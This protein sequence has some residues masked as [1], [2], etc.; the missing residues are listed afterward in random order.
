[1]P[2]RVSRRNFRAHFGGEGGPYSNLNEGKCYSNPEVIKHLMN[3]SI[4]SGSFGGVKPKDTSAL[5]R[6]CSAS[7]D[8][9]MCNSGD[10]SR[11]SAYPVNCTP[12][13]PG[14][15][16]GTYPEGSSERTCVVIPNS[17]PCLWLTEPPVPD[18]LRDR[19]GAR[20]R[21]SSGRVTRRRRSVGRGARRSAGRVSRRVTRRRR[22]SS[23]R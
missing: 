4:V 13:G 14:K 20:R 1:M 17:R 2:R 15:D 11:P 18:H 10:K 8:K 7:T 19:G 3:G 22:R 16:T 21:R 5:D 12:D 6:I 9:F 23:R